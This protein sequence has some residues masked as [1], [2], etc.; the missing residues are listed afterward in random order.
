MSL[1]GYD[2]ALASILASITPLG[3]ETVVA[4]DA[5]GR[6]LAHDLAVPADFPDQPRSAVDGYALGSCDRTSFALMGE[7]AAGGRPLP[8]LKANEAAAVMTGAVV[9]SGTVAVVMLEQTSVDG[10]D[11]TVGMTTM[12]GDLI[13]P[14]GSEVHQGAPLA[15]AG[16]RLDV[17]S[18]AALMAAGLTELTVHR[19]PKVGLLI[20]G[21][22]VGPTP[23]PGAVFD[24]NS[25]IL[26][27]VCAGLGCEVTACRHIGDAEAAT[28]AILA[29]LAADCDLII[30]SG[31]VSK[32]R[33]DHVGHI[34][35]GDTD[36][37]LL[38]GTAIKPGRPMHV[39][40]LT[41][42]TPVF[43]MPGYPTALLTN[44]F[45]YLVP[46]LKALGGRRGAATRWLAATLGDPMR[47]R[48]ERLYLNRATLTLSNGNWVAG[49][50]GSQI[51]S[52]FLNFTRVQGLVR[53]PMTPPPG[54]TRGA[55]KLDAGQSVQ[56]LHFA[57]E[58]S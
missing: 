34:L 54:H 38:Q 44:T 26:K 3:V 40:R 45:L 53:M 16:Q 4:A 51:S 46:A 22:E 35:R 55:A 37:L 10:D 47:Y 8:P 27:A 19:R 33:Y 56:A 9:P 48:P 24:A 20:T 1:P 6:V 43:G 50:P 12:P 5:L 39:A 18:H 41:D 30:T 21:D 52:H 28:R 42:D 29:E 11:L 49:D 13:N 2:Q 17:A 57:L 31:G 25:Y 36:R 14:A 23:A 7:V 32:G 15:S 58:L